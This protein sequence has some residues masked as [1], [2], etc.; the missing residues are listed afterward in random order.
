MISIKGEFFMKNLV[1]ALMAVLISI[2]AASAYNYITEKQTIF[3]NPQKSIWTLMPE[4]EAVSYT[5]LTL[6]TT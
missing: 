6:P 4:T 5:H 3:Y 2:S 1:I